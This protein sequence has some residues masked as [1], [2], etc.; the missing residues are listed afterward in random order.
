M[1]KQIA[2]AMLAGLAMLAGGSALADGIARGSMKDVP[3]AVPTW[4]GFYLGAG[5]G[6]GHLI[7]KNRYN[8]ND[9]MR[10]SFAS[11]VSTA[12]ALAAASA[13]LTGLRPPDPGPL[14]RRP[15]HGVRLVQHRDVLPGHRH[16]ASRPSALTAPSRSVDAAVSCLR[17][18]PC[19]IL[20]GGYSWSHGKND[21]YFD[22]DSTTV[23]SP[24][25]EAQP[26]GPPSSASA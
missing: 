6:Y 15:V 2:A 13:R 1:R 14:R 26:A 10:K 3:V 25:A 5:V 7:A 24:P 18:R 8:E 20:T 21:G 16:A 19:S 11:I 17:R 9:T 12:K 22:I 23:S 4:S